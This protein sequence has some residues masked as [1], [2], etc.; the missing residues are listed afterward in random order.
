MA[1]GPFISYVPPGVYTRTLA[2]NNVSN[3]VAGL[4][5]P[6]IIGVGQ[7]E[8]ETLDLELVR[9]S[10]SD[11]DTPITAEDVSLQWVV[12]ASNPQNP[13]LGAQN[14]ALT[15][16]RVRNFPIVDGQG[17]GRVTNDTRTVVV[18][19][20]GIA[21]A[22]GAVQGAKGLVTL[23]VPTQ[24]TDTVRCSYKFHRGDTTFTDTLSDQVTSENAT[25]IT[26][27]F[28]PYNIAAGSTDTFTI[29]VNG[30]TA[31][32]AL[33]PNSATTA[34]GMKSQIDAA[35]V[36]G[37]TTSV[38]VDPQGRDC[39]RFT[40]TVSLEIGAG[41]ANGPL[42]LTVGTQTSRNRAFRVFNRPI[43]DGTGGGVTTT[44]T[45]KVVVKVN[46]TQVIPASVDGTNG[47][48]TL[49]TAPAPGATVTIAYWANTWQDTFDYLPNTFVSAVIRSGIAPGRNDYIQGTDFVISNPSPDVSIINWGT[50]YT[51]SASR[52]TVGATAFDTKQVIPTLV[53]SQMFLAECTAV[54]DTSVIPA[55]VST[56]EFLLPEIPTTGNGRN[57]VL[58]SED[59][60]SVTNGRVDLV[61]N[62]PDLVK[63]WS[64][65]TLRDALNRSQLTVASVDGASRKVTLKNAV[66]PDHNVY[67]TFY[68]NK[69][70]DDTFLLTCT[71]PGP[72][73]AGQYTVT[74]TT[75]NEN[76]YQVK[77]GS[78]SGLSQTVQWPRGS[79]LVPDAMHT[80][81]GTAVSEVVTVTFGTEA[82]TNAAY[83][84]KGAGPWSFYSSSSTWVTKVNGSDVTTNLNAAA[85][86]WLIGSHLTVNG[87]DQITIPA[88]PNNVL[89]LTI[90]DV[91]I[92]VTLTAGLRTITQILTE[93]NAAI[94][95]DAAF[96]GTA[97]NA[98]ATSFQIGGAGGD[99]MLAIKSYSTPA[100]LPGGFDHASY[101]RVR[102]G[103]VEGTLGFTTFQRA[104]GT[105]KAIA[106]NAT[107]LGTIAG[108]F[109]ITAGLN[110][111]FKV[112]VNGI[113]YE[114]TLPAGAAVTTA[115]VVAAINAVPGLTSVSSAG[116][117]GNLDQLRLM[118]PTNDASS[119]LVILDGTA[120]DVLGFTENDQASQTLVAVQEVVDRL[121][122]TGGFVSG[123]VAYSSSLNGNTYLT[124]ESLT[125][126]AATS[127]IGFTSSATSAF[128][129]QSGTKITPGTDGDNGEDA[130][131]N[132]VVTSSNA[133]GS[134]GTGYPGQTYTDSVTGLRFTVLPATTGSY[135]AAGYFTLLVSQTFDV[136]PSIPT[137]AIP[138][139]EMTVTNTVGVG[140]NDLASVQT[141]APEGVEPK[142]G[143]FYYVSYRYLK[144][145][146]Q[147]RL[148]QQLKTIEA[149]FGRTSTENR[150]TLGAYLAIL[151][152]ALLVGISQVQKQ[153]NTNQ[154]SAQ[155]F[156]GAIAALAK[157]LQGNILPDI[158]VPLA[159]D[160]SVY[161]FLTNHC[162]IQS[163]IRNQ[164]ERMG[165][166]G[167]ASG[168]TPTA[169][170]SVARSLGS[171][172]IVAY[173]PDSA[174]ITLT[175]E[176]GQSFEEIVDGTF[177]AAAAAGAVVSP[178]IDVATPYSRRRIIGFTRIPR[179]LDPVE[180]NQTAVAGVTLL[181]DLG[182]LI[183]IRHGLTT[184]MDSILT[185][186]P[187]VTQIS[188]FVQQQSRAT[189]D[190]FVGTKFLNSRTTE[191]EV[192]MTSLLK[193][194]LQAE[195]IGAFTGV[196]AEVDPN[197]PT[198]LR[199]GAF[200]QPIF[201]LLYLVL[202][203]NLRA[204][205]GGQR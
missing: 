45:S 125:T 107:L 129:I 49:A 28:A 16:F 62:R 89:E 87:S 202:T 77:F 136:T 177:F 30:A 97:P 184:Q 47:V 10:S 23:Q 13:V 175:D 108:P 34:A 74:S 15:T 204:N 123:A 92:T 41:T 95:A 100:A 145:D 139:L 9:G 19:V 111:L 18:T 5:I 201:P 83:T 200:Y 63:V 172:R 24:P 167:F 171:N 183:R 53:D 117:L 141:F 203:F 113:D 26:P 135:S 37:L 64:G 14:G 150:V 173:Y 157:P 11:V 99:V 88:S 60:A 149:N 178:A 91:D 155:S 7:E 185:R 193:Q 106:K 179:V 48:V 146:Y 112:R 190:A 17:L 101:V 70:S 21:V 54:T 199:F 6:V 115:A 127:S 1:L 4:R 103:T 32:I 189:L 76:L 191:V 67:A 153:P 8:L 195:I 176:V 165:M 65:R 68:Y 134:A 124:I 198:I 50:S 181:D 138:G 3:V 55:L 85:K 57:T 38:F 192:A 187:T 56:T 188:D 126:G 160:S 133:S 52:T 161:A 142:V 33:L 128:N 51:V 78:K 43:V 31:S 180:A 158:I 81:D 116:T 46:G 80:G 186:L 120:N 94:D 58:S 82:A 156:N 69:V 197:D 122:S 159:T 84:T 90:D 109:N 22:I 114:I 79:E 152:G 205:L 194:L 162:E 154:A 102:Q 20:N 163:S 174:V 137:Y 12:D 93:I 151:N 27:G 73:G 71:V 40:A 105:P 66:P 130:R 169:A 42:G 119:S 104:D 144:Q 2:E 75:R 170:Q 196:Q 72:V 140:V 131:D 36:T 61:S 182:T 143:D 110:D 25:L 121:M 98:L 148:F 29:I 118:S 44:D 164:A 147:T 96:L 35:G 86:G 168:T 132:F 166:I 39:L 59:F